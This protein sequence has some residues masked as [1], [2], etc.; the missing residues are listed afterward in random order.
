MGYNPTN[1]QLYGSDIGSN[2]FTINIAT[3]ART[4]DRAHKRSEP[5]PRTRI[6]QRCLPESDSNADR[7]RHGYINAN[8]DS[9]GNIY[10]NSYSYSDIY[11]YTHGDCYGGNPD[12]NADVHARR[13]PSA[14]RQCRL[15]R[16]GQYP[17]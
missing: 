2:L 4:H 9:Y 16:P 8:T 3:G 6:R 12:P 11:S 13:I 1:G 14:D 15:R 10:A 7:N 17:A 5:Q